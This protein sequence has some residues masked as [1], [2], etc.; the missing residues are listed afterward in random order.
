MSDQQRQLPNLFV[1]VAIIYVSLWIL[2]SLF[3]WTTGKPTLAAIGTV[4]IYLG[5]GLTGVSVLINFNRSGNS[6]K[7][8]E[9]YQ[10]WQARPSDAVTEWAMRVMLA[11]IPLAI[12]GFFVI[13]LATCGRI[14]CG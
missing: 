7:Q 11:S 14:Y 6:F 2:A 4:L 1:S 3:C 10:K 8:I 12:S 9:S 5:V 13:H